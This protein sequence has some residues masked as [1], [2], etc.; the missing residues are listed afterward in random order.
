MTRELSLLAESAANA[1]N[2]EAA[3]DRARD[4]GIEDA[5]WQ[6]RPLVGEL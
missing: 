3:N 6:G 4:R 1:A 2:D 5:Y